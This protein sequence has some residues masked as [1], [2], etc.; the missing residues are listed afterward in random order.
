MHRRIGFSRVS[1]IAVLLAGV[2]LIAAGCSREA[3]VAAAQPGPEKAR[4]FTINDGV[5]ERP[6]GYR[7]WI[8][9]G[10]PVT[11]NSLNNGKAPFP[12]FHNVYID[13]DAWAQWKDTGRF[14]DGTILMKELV[15]VGATQA[16]SGNGFF[17]GD[18]IGLEAEIKS[19]KH[20]PNEPG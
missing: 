1:L 2:G 8:Y 13:P 11:P 18:Y 17:E 7:E 4:W 20:F 19:A 5:L 16:V 3:Q 6:V 15:S 9:V 10:T 14:P 12:E